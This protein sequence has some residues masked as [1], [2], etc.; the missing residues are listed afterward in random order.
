MC[1]YIY[2]HI[3]I[4]IHVCIYIHIYMCHIY[5]Y[6]H[7]YVFIHTHI[8]IYIVRMTGIKEKD[9]NQN[10]MEFRNRQPKLIIQIL[11]GH[12]TLTDYIE[13][14]VTKLCKTG[15]IIRKTS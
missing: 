3:Q 5:I 7:T 8:Y 1:V 10:L 14:S 11:Q 13:T 4:Y 12:K 15:F 9:V 2:I 6:T